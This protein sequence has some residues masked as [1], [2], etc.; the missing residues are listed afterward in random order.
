MRERAPRPIS[1][2]NLPLFLGSVLLGATFLHAQVT[3]TGPE[4]QVNTYTDLDQEAVAVAMDAAARFVVVWQSADPSGNDSDPWSIE[5]RRFGASTIAA[6][7]WE[8]SSRSTR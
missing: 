1:R 6:P 5:G 3:P 7:R 2:A 8:I 4:F